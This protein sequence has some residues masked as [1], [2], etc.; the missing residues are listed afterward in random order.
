LRC[1]A[2]SDKCL[3]ES[4][5]LSFQQH[6]EATS[7]LLQRH[8]S[9]IFLRGTD[10]GGPLPTL[11]VTTESR[12]VAREFRAFRSNRTAQELALPV[13]FRLVTNE[14]D[15]TPDT[16]YLAPG[17]G[18]GPSSSKA[19]PTLESASASSASSIPSFT[20][21]EAMV[22]ALS[23]LQHQLLARATVANCC[24]NFHL[25][26]AELLAA[27]CGAPSSYSSSAS[28]SS[29]SSASPSSSSL[30]GHTLHCLQEHFDPRYRVCCGWAAKCK[31]RKRWAMLAQMEEEKED[32]NNNNNRTK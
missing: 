21:D 15:V 2:A 32:N 29:S 9:D 25:L 26:L 4:E 20:A 27:G 19:R 7:G 11:L 28:P 16:G 1:T 14:A 13:R 22:S 6:V 10:A 8:H 31:E 18:P 3:R 30:F 24:S 5:C 12:D 17:P 23:T